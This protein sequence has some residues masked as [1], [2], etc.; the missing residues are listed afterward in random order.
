MRD[1]HQWITRGGATSTY[2]EYPLTIKP[3]PPAEPA[4]PT[5]EEREKRLA[6]NIKHQCLMFKKQAEKTGC[7]FIPSL[8]ASETRVIN[9]TITDIFLL[10]PRQ[11]GLAGTDIGRMSFLRAAS[12]LGLKSMDKNLV[13]LTHIPNNT[14]Y[15][16]IH[17]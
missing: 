1:T 3:L 7:L 13:P 4:G 17:K 2:R 15:E 11:L 16:F 12:G 10:S 6:D 9:K 5:K 8:V 14:K